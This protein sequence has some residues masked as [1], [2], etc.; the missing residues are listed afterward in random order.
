MVVSAEV[1]GWAATEFVV[2]EATMAWSVPDI[3]DVLADLLA[4]AR[5]ISEEPA[6]R[7]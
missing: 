7:A 6:A 3:V 4:S 1:P 5:Q 2:G